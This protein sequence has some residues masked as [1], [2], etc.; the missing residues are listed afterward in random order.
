MVERS[1]G[2]V[3]LIRNI[4]AGETRPLFAA[5]WLIDE[6]AILQEM[7]VKKNFVGNFVLIPLE[8]VAG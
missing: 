5:T 3:F 6:T 4:E 7:F 2:N 1:Q 8:G